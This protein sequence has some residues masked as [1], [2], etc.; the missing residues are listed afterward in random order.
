METVETMQAQPSRT[1]LLGLPAELCEM[2]I[3]D[4]AC[5]Q[6][7]LAKQ[8]SEMTDHVAE[9]F[10]LQRNRIIRTTLHQTNRQLRH[11]YLYYYL[12]REAVVFDLIVLVP[13][14]SKTAVLAWAKSLGGRKLRLVK[15]LVIQETGARGEVPLF[16][17]CPSGQVK[18]R[19]RITSE[20]ELSESF[21]QASRRR[22]SDLE[23]AYTPLARYLRT[24]IQLKSMISWQKRGLRLRNGAL[25][26]SDIYAIVA[27]RENLR[28]LP[29][30]PRWP[31]D[32]SE[33]TFLQEALMRGSDDLE[34]PMEKFKCFSYWTSVMVIK[35]K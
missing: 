6:H 31:G 30:P 12:Q 25:K 14:T 29:I 18:L 4:F 27:S 33:L 20:I 9:G 21:G 11:E 5:E 32:P 35:I 8:L 3:Y 7:C 15:Y 24:M 26:L 13:E 19:G 23:S 10:K 2:M 1:S 34:K 16:T 17:I 22:L 28:F